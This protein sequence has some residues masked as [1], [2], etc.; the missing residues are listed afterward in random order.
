MS[1]SRTLTAVALM[2][3]ALLGVAG[4]TEVAEE[5]GETIEQQKDQAVERIGD[6]LQEGMS[7][8][9]DAAFES[10]DEAVSGGDSEEDAQS[11]DE[12]GG[13]EEPED[14]GGSN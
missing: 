14:G 2:A 9:Q 10:A 1:M 4:C 11:R 3:L 13:D 7:E 5:V 6:E 12:L 8:H